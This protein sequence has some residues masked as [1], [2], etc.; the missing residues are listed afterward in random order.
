MSTGIKLSYILTNEAFAFMREIETVVCRKEGG[1]YAV[2]FLY[3]FMLFP[4]CSNRILDSSGKME[5]ILAFTD[6]LYLC[7]ECV[8]ICGRNT[9]SDRCF[10]L[11][12]W[13]VTRKKSRKR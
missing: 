13:P 11:C 5:K 12:I 2:F 9:S 1:S 8:G 4:N 7:Y 3:I 6:K 10:Q